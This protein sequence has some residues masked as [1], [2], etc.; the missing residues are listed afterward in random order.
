MGIARV[1]KRRIAGAKI[2][3]RNPHA[4]LAELVQERERIGF[5][6]EQYGHFSSPPTTNLASMPIFDIASAVSELRFPL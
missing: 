6:L 4:D 5:V 1:R 2:V 3:H